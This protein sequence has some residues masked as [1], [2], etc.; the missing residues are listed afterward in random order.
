MTNPSVTRTA[1][2]YKVV[3]CT[4]EE[5]EE[6]VSTNMRYGLIRITSTGIE[7]EGYHSVRQGAAM[8]GVLG[9]AIGG[10]I[11]GAISAAKQKRARSWWQVDPSRAR[12]LYD[13]RK[14]VVSI[15]LPE[16]DWFAARLQGGF[17]GVKPQEFDAF[18]DDLRSVFGPRLIRGQLGK[19]NRR[20]RIMMWVFG[21]CMFTAAFLIL[22]LYLSDKGH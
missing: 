12:A 17:W 2:E 22:V 9:G 3:F 14:R 4:T 7:M 5:A 11:A 15:A 21:A 19:W 18:V 10:A 16:G 20:M 13:D 8:G 6:T 1:R